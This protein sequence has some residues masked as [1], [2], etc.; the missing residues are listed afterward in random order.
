MAIA[1]QDT[2]AQP[3]VTTLDILWAF[4]QSQPKRVKRAFRTRM[5]AEEDTTA[6]AQWQIDLEGIKALKEN[7]NE[8]DAKPINRKAIR[9]VLRI[10][11]ML[12][13]RV[14]ADVRLY[15]TPLG[16]V[17]VK[18]ET[19]KGR[20]K[21]EIGDKQMSYFIKRAN[22]PTEHHSFEDLTKETL[23]SLIRNMEEIS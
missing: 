14:A 23:S 1:I 6:P 12:A 8:E 17:M 5:E 21:G 18:L 2:N 7:W 16:A 22:A 15:P 20:I 10:M 13:T 3:K 9:N 4:Y 19:S 11:D